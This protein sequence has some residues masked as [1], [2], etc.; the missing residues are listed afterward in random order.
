[1]FPK[2]IVWL[3]LP[4][5]FFVF[6]AAGCFGTGA[7]FGAP[8][9]TT[10]IKGVVAMPLNECYVAHC[11]SPQVSEGESAALAEI[12]L[13]KE[14][15]TAY[16]TAVTDACGQYEIDSVDDACYILYAKA[17][18][19]DAIVKKGISGLT[20]GTMNDVGEANYYTTAQVIIYEVAK[21]KYGD[22]VKCS[23][24]S[25]FVPTQALLDAVKK[26]LS[27]CRDA[28][29][30]DL[31]KTY[32]T[33]VADS[34]FGAPCTSC[35]PVTP[36]SKCITLPA[37]TIGYTPNSPQLNEAVTFSVT[38][39][40]A[41]PNNTTFTW[42]FGDKGTVTGSS[43][44]HTYATAGSYTVSVTANHK[45]AC[46]P[47]N[48][49]V[50]VSFAE[51]SC[52]AEYGID[53]FLSG[54]TEASLNQEVTFTASYQD[55][56]YNLPVTY[57][58][59]VDGNQVGESSDTL[60]HTFATSGTHTVKVVIGNE[61]GSGEDTKE[62]QVS[63]QELKIS[64]FDVDVSCSCPTKG[65]VRCSTC[66]PPCE[67]CTITISKI[68]FTGTRPL[69]YRYGYR[70]KTGLSWSPWTWYPSALDWTTDTSHTFTVQGVCTSQQYEVAVQAYNE[71]TTEPAQ[72]TKTGT[73]DGGY[74][75]PG[76]NTSDSN[77]C[78]KITSSSSYNSAT[79][80][81]TFTYTVERLSEGPSCQ[82][83]SHW[84]LDFGETIDKSRIVSKDGG[85]YTGQNE[86]TGVPKDHGIKWSWV[87]SNSNTF[88]VVITG[89]VSANTNNTAGKIKSGQSTPVTSLKVCQPE[90]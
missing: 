58:W 73:L 42:D 44:Q 60:E 40:N 45:K 9:A 24:I 39:A 87:W 30:D 22:A 5:V 1:M 36:P 31:V 26:A 61:C 16:K 70:V 57:T 20:S 3:S 81:T 15:G 83:I 8:G 84:V 80:K 48:A 78:Y 34:L 29:K 54:P 53:A 33:G 50:G 21:A 56:G 28:Q 18:G 12:T 47:T 89:C 63:C 65:D 85:S 69:G 10:G 51:S 41:F 38:N 55:G 88:T 19:G 13:Q 27:E 35:V 77:G 79:N 14:D 11:D 74:C 2:K 90:L 43:V 76:C 71:C 25:G 67:N 66:P 59:Y 7:Q 52:P 37:P 49:G 68:Q 72:K 46:A 6:F 64:G 32:A 4:L 75:C 23:D 62:I 17:Q 82:E 86:P